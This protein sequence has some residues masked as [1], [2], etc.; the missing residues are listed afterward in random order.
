MKG[1]IIIMDILL[2]DDE[3]YVTESLEATIPWEKLGI[4]HVYRT[5]SAAAALQLLQSHPVDILVTDIRMPGMDGLE[6]IEKAGEKWPEIRSILLTGYSDFQYAKK[7]I[8]LQAQDYILKPVDDEEFIKS[9][10]QTIE[11]IKEREKETDKYHQ[12]MYQRKSDYVLLRE[13][14]LQ[15]L[16]LGTPHTM[17]RVKQQLQDYEIPLQTDFESI[18]ILVQLNQGFMDL[19]S[20]SRVLIEYAIGNISEEIL[21]ANYKVWQGRTPHHC[22]AVLIQTDNAAGTEMKD[23]DRR[24]LHSLLRTFQENVRQY[25]HGDISVIISSGFQ[26]P[27]DASSVYHQMLN[28]MYL[29]S[30]DEGA[31][32]LYSPD[33]QH[34]ALSGTTKEVFNLLYKPPVLQ[35]LLELGQWGSVRERLSEVF[36][37]MDRHPVSREHMYEIYLAI[38]NACLYI[39]HRTDIRISELDVHGMEPH[40]VERLIQYP[41]ELRNYTFRILDKLEEDQQDKPP[42][43]GHIVK[44]VKD[45]VA[46]EYGYE[47]TVKMIADRV[48]LHPVYLSKVFKAETGEGLSEYLIRIRLEKAL[49]LLKHTNKKIYEIT[50][51]LGY[52]NPQ[53]FSKLF[54]K[55]FGMSPNEFRE[56]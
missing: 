35:Q 38:I 50:S 49:Y 26:F 21:G 53:Y 41:A 15:G 6:L 14:M 9:V 20:K 37:V 19:D 45:M 51:E 24:Q 11:A 27:N 1:T 54:K 16:L 31:A 7:A 34:R 40:H 13:N 48:F 36:D 23:R 3:S 33:D 8:Q 29:A 44:Q 10:N 43:K 18:M 42:S 39:T 56:Q 4:R 46:S 5:D 12:L 22:L 17:S 47:L 52:Q 32:V 28:S 55:H 25:L 30:T 2:V